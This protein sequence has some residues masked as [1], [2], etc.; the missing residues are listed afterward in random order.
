M[1]IFALPSPVRQL[2]LIESGEVVHRMAGL[3]VFY[4]ESNGGVPAVMH[5]MLVNMP[6]LYSSM[7]FLTVR[8]VAVP[9]VDPKER[10][11]V[12]RYGYTDRVDFSGEE[13]N[14]PFM[15][16]LVYM[17]LKHLLERKGVGSAGAAVRLINTLAARAAAVAAVAAVGGPDNEAAG[18][19]QPLTR[20]AELRGG[21]SAVHGRRGSVS[22]GGGRA[23]DLPP[24][25]SFSAGSISQ[26]LAAAAEAA[27]TTLKALSGSNLGH[28]VLLGG[29]Y[30]FL[31]D[32]TRQV[33][34]AW[35]IPTKHL[36]ELGMDIEV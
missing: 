2:V 36:I 21:S 32:N 10:L 9:T 11:L 18:S 23:I 4:S 3:G 12:R 35:N 17:L 31:A 33:T 28:R 29:L 1:S 27:A 20:L 6:C 8:A 19:K 22:A 30:R 16:G 24:S 25:V 34:G 26:L 14:N 13:Q 7:V 5:H 15:D